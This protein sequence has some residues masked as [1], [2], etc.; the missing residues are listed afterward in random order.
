MRA[1]TLLASHAEAAAQLRALRNAA[2]QD[3]KGDALRARWT[4]LGLPA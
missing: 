4:Q 1:S 3:A 2:L